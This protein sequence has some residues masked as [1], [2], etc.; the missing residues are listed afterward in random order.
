MQKSV[1][2]GAKRSKRGRLCNGNGRKMIGNASGSGPKTTQNSPQNDPQKMNFWSLWDPQTPQ[3][4]DIPRP[5]CCSD[6][7]PLR[8][9]IKRNMSHS[10]HW[11]QSQQQLAL[12]SRV[13]EKW[14]YPPKMAK[15][16]SGGPCPIAPLRKKNF[17]DFRKTSVRKHSE[18][19]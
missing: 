3:T 1:I 2:L 13:F 10:D 17:S 11:N 8:P 9:L 12:K 19:S 15:Y 16:A 6:R 4:F 14:S 5:N 7:T 18:H